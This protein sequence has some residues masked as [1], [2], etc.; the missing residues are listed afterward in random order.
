MSH[1]RPSTPPPSMMAA[2]PPCKRS[3]LSNVHPV[4]A[5]YEEGIRTTSIP[6]QNTGNSNCG[7]YACAFVAEWFEWTT[8][9]DTADF[10]GLRDGTSVHNLLN[11]LRGSNHNKIAMQRFTLADSLQRFTETLQTSASSPI[12]TSVTDLD[13]A[14]GHWMVVFDKNNGKL[15]VFDPIDGNIYRVPVDVFCSKFATDMPETLIQITNV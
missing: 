10:V 13:N 9:I 2:E 6:P 11:R 7:V 1:S 8:P 5:G 15:S 4:F 3:R 14:E 12:I